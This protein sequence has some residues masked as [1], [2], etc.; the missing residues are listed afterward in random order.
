MQIQFHLIVPFF[1]SSSQRKTKA[2]SGS[3]ESHEGGKSRP[4]HVNSWSLFASAHLG[5]DFSARRGIVNLRVF[6]GLIN[7]CMTN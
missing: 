7:L 5:N 6:I 1:Y 2:G 3:I 4:L